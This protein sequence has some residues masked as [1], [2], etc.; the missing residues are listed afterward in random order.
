MCMQKEH[1]HVL[2]CVFSEDEAIM[3][4][5]APKADGLVEVMA[6]MKND[7]RKLKYKVC[8]IYNM[9]HHKHMG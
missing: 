4:R 9:S 3:D 7:V 2:C 6:A 5:N 8:H 1:N